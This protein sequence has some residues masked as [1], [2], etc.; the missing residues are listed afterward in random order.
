MDCFPL[1]VA[2]MLFSISKGLRMLDI[3]VLAKVSLW[4]LVQAKYRVR[5]YRVLHDAMWHCTDY[6]T[7]THTA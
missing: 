2:L 1:L 3:C 5:K 4:V 6:H 7:I